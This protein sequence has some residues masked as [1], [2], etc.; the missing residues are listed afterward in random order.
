MDA[1]KHDREL[2][3]PERQVV[4][5]AGDVATGQLGI[6]GRGLRPG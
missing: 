4:A 3:A 2:E 1:L 6:P 5:N